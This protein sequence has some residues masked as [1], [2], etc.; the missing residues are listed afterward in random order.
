LAPRE[1]RQRLCGI[2]PSTIDHEVLSFDPTEVE[3]SDQRRDREVQ[4][5][6]NR[7][8]GISSV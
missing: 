6:S 4:N 5:E 1:L 3:A 7:F 2:G 8:H